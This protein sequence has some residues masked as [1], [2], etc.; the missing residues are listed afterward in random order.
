MRRQILGLSALVLFFLVLTPG[1]V[2]A[3]Q[4]PEYSKSD[5][6]AYIK[7]HWPQFFANKR[8]PK[9]MMPTGTPMDKKARMGQILQNMSTGYEKQLLH[10]DTLLSKIESRRDKMAEEGKDTSQIDEALRKIEERK[11]KLQEQFAEKKQK[12]LSVSPSDTPASLKEK[13]GPELSA[14]RESFKDLHGDVD[15]LVRELKAAA[16]F[17]VTPRPTKL[18]LPTGTWRQRKP[19]ISVPPPRYKQGAN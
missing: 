15:D 9:N 18:L 2:M 19:M 3:Q 4:E 6:R 7:K 1:T 14:L 16:G 17:T 8:L 5:I 13:L 10:Y 11:E 12:L